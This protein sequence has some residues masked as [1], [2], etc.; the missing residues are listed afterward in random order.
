MATA[1]TAGDMEEDTE[2]DTE[3]ATVDMVTVTNTAMGTGDN[4]KFI[5]NSC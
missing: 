4:N 2:V 1:D 3:E 5:V